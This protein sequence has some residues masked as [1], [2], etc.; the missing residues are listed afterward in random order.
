MDNIPPNY[1]KQNYW[2]E[3]VSMFLEFQKSSLDNCLIGSSD[4]QTYPWYKIAV[5]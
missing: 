3:V 4:L 5:I 2:N 1:D